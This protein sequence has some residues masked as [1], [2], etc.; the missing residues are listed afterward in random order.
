MTRRGN[1]SAHWPVTLITCTVLVLAGF[2]LTA[3]DFNSCSNSVCGRSDY[4]NGVNGSQ[5]PG[6]QVTTPAASSAP[7]T[8]TP[9]QPTASTQQGR[10]TWAEQ[11]ASYGSPTFTDPA[12]AS[13]A[14]PRIAAMRTVQV[15]C[16]VHDPAITSANPGGWWYRIATKPWNGAYYAIANTFWNGDTPGQTPYTHYTDLTVKVC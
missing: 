10:H 2:S 6:S 14:G 5:G 7:T 8:F 13:G 9:T 1:A 4:G 15:L 12:N 3:C 11:S 16:R